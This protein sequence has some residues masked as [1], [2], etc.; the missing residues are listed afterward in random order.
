ME[1][2]GEMTSK[3][4]E[5]LEALIRRTDKENPNPEDLAKMRCILDQDDTLVRLNKVSEHAFRRVIKSYSESALVTELLERQI[6][7]ARKA[8]DYETANAFVKM[9]I[10]QV[11]LNNIRLNQLEA[12]HVSK[13]GGNHCTEEGLYWDK[14]LSSAQ[15]RFLKACESL[16]KVKKLLSEADLREAQ[17]NGKKTQNTLASQRLYKALSD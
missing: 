9:L 12:L 10:D 5:T 1:T 2:K 11:I 16:A 8:L 6:K 7:D 3:K 15:K 4:S 14:R 17:A 13:L